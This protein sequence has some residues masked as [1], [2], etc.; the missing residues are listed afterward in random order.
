ML[1]DREL[2]S[3]SVAIPLL[4]GSILLPFDRGALPVKDDEGE[5]FSTPEDAI[6]AGK[7]S[8]RDIAKNRPV[9]EVVAWVLSVTD[10][11]GTEIASFT[12]SDYRNALESRPGTDAAP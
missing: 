11:M 6:A 12:I 5:E 8:A 7:E 9:S 1:S 10:E 4:H 2:T 3:R